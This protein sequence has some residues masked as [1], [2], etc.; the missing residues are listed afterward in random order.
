MCLFLPEE[1]LKNGVKDKEKK[2][3]KKKRKKIKKKIC[4]IN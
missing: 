1:T 3:K 4:L 2:K